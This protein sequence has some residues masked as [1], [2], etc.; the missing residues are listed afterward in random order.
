M[1]LGPQPKVS[2]PQFHLLHFQEL[3]F[4]CCAV[5]SCREGTE[6]VAW[7]DGFVSSSA[8]KSQQLSV[9]LFLPDAA[10]FCDTG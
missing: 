1:T 5:Q 2:L 9:L 10:Y 6:A 4:S 7:S 3:R 8:L